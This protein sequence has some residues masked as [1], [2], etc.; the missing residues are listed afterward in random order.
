MSVCSCT[1]LL[2]LEE[3]GA[4]EYVNFNI[5]ASDYIMTRGADISEYE[6]QDA[7]RMGTEESGLWLTSD[8]VSRT[9]GVPV[10]KGIQVTND[11]FADKYGEFTVNAFAYD[12]DSEWETGRSDAQSYIS[13]EIISVN[14]L[15]SSKFWP[16][17]GS[18]L[19]FY[20]NAPC[21]ADGADFSFDE[22]KNLTLS[23]EVPSK[24]K[25]QKDILIASPIDMSYA[26]AKTVELKFH[27]VLTSVR[28]KAVP[29]E[30][31]SGTVKSVTLKNIASSGIYKCGDLLW[32]TNGETKDF[33]VKPDISL[34]YDPDGTNGV[35]DIVA[36]D[37][38][39]IMIPQTLAENSELEVV[40]ESDGKE[41]VL[42]AKMSG[43][44]WPMDFSTGKTVIYTI[45]SEYD[46]YLKT[47]PEITDYI[48]PETTGITYKG[49]NVVIDVNSDQ[50]LSG[51]GKKDAEW[52]IDDEYEIPEWVTIKEDHQNNTV[53]ISLRRVDLTYV[54]D[55]HSLLVANPPVDGVYDLSTK[56]GA[57]PMNTANCYI[58]NAPGKYK[59]PLVYGNAVVNGSPNPSSYQPTVSGDYVM[60]QIN[61]I[62]NQITSPYIY[63][64]EGCKPVGA[65]LVWLD[66][67][68]G[69]GGT[70]EVILPEEGL[71]RNVALDETKQYL[72]F[73]VDQTSM[74]QGN[75]IVAVYGERG[76]IMWS[77]HIW[78]TDYEPMG[79]VLD[80]SEGWNIPDRN[81]DARLLN[82][83]RIVHNYTGQKYTFMPI[84]I[85]WVYTKD[86]LY[87]E[88]RFKIRIRQIVTGKYADIEIVQP[89]DRII[90]GYN[91]Y[92]QMF[93][94]DPLAPGCDNGLIKDFYVTSELLSPLDTY[95]NTDLKHYTHRNL[96]SSGGYRGTIL[97]PYV[98]MQV[99]TLYPGN[100]LNMNVLEY[101]N[102]NAA[103]NL[104]NNACDSPVNNGLDVQSA[105]KTIYDPTPVGYCVPPICAY[106]GFTQD[107]LHSSG[108]EKYFGS[109]Y[110]NSYFLSTEDPDEH[111]GYF[112]YCSPMTYVEEKSLWIKP[113]Y[114]GVINFPA[115]G[116]ITHGTSNL[117]NLLGTTG[118][119][120]SSLCPQDSNT[121]IIFYTTSN[122]A[123]YSKEYRGRA[124]SMR[125]V[126]YEGDVLYK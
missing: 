106:S 76:L 21:T 123:Q 109:N 111:V 24:V 71:V 49:G 73:D 33:T 52:V 67:K 27:H 8:I 77:W 19:R 7:V 119:C 107:G 91:P 13:N 1:D 82:Y 20:A 86:E 37:S 17:D 2:S 96:Q 80:S 39:F 110:Q 101:Y 126:R 98:H 94:K 36:G 12:K 62:G 18:K 15:R 81:H 100:A 42:K 116:E 43:L 60:P 118:V 125:A 32:A 121:H 65:M 6:A 117:M 14:K 88:R 30:Y 55:H 57:T 72:T 38:T 61:H 31:L 64:N 11:N 66:T 47:T 22:N 115:R 54:T 113:H 58:V 63:E 108:T 46:F 9:S 89:G 79:T 103:F 35:V 16:F 120:T 26:D 5:V 122:R 4:E 85:G 104:W 87:A 3:K 41:K 74:R 92:F 59:L 28:I 68:D 50:I 45:R 48:E 90:D 112:G 97:Y 40:L 95:E 75:A 70:Y 25:N 29:S 34:V 51:G 93:R 84:N 23:Y 83:D 10:T 105:I 53:N 124:F 99:G 69:T 102:G 78:I 56:G 114:E 44:V